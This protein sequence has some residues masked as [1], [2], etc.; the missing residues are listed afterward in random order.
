MRRIFTPALGARCLALGL[1]LLLALPVFSL[2][3]S[4]LGEELVELGGWNREKI[5][6]LLAE[7]GR[8]PEPGE[9]IEFISAAF[10]DTPYLADTLIG[11]AQTAEVLVLRLDAV[12]CF[13]F[14]DY[15]EALRRAADFSGFKEAL[16]RIRYRDGRVDFFSRHH[17]F[18]E[19]AAA[20]SDHLQ[21]V[22]E[23]VG[24]AGAR[25]AK[26]RLN[27]K[28]DGTAY[29]PG[30]PV[31]EREITFIPPEAIDSSV[32]ERLRSG[33]YVGI[34]SPLPGLDVSHT[35]IVVKRGGQVLLRHAS[36]SSRL[37]KVVDQEL[38][39]YLAGSKGLVVYR[40]GGP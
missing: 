18:S 2:P 1:A 20:N 37:K 36:S 39:S 3:G 4:A 29:L 7:A 14:L 38:S 35:G 9:K 10:L 17:F 12:D 40:P 32:L 26:K 30:Y 28:G 33:D 15:V 22:T 6:G 5:E 16:R 8:I 13:T 25:R 21:R 23:L 19:W 27:A 31:R 11:S 34:Y 24:G